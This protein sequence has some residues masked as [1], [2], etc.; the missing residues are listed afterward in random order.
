MLLNP[1]LLKD[2]SLWSS[3]Y[4]FQE[5]VFA[6][7]VVSK[8]LFVEVLIFWV[9]LFNKLLVLLTSLLLAL[10]PQFQRLKPFYI[11][12]ANLE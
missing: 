4:D 1:T 5:K 10:F 7:V 3:H 9:L 6:V 2:E 12:F 8:S 11:T